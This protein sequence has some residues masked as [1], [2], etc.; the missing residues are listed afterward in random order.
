LPSGSLL[1]LEGDAR[2]GARVES[3]LGPLGYGV[4]IVADADEA[5][6]Q[7]PG[8]QLL[9]IDVVAGPRTAD[10]VCREIRS[11]PALAAIPVLCV[12][13]S[14]DVEER[15]HFLEAG[16]DDVI[17]KP[18]D[19]R[20]LEARVEALMVRFRQ[21]PDLSPVSLPGAFGRAGHRVIV[22]FSPKGGVGTTTIAVNT[23][24]A[25]AAGRQG[26]V[27]LVDLDLQW[28]QVA[29]HLNLR[30]TMTLAELS[31]DE[32]ALT[33]P[34]LL[35]SYGVAHDSGVTVLCAPSRP[36]QATLIG[37]SHVERV[38]RGATALYD[39]V[40]VDAGSS[41]DE[42][43]LTAFAQADTT[44]FTIYPEIAALKALTGLLELFAEQGRVGRTVFVLNH[45]FSRDMLKIRD[46]ETA[47]AARI[48]L[49]LPY[50]PLL[51]LKAVNEGVPIVRGAPRSEPAVR[52]GRLSGLLLGESGPVEPEAEVA[53]P[54]GRLGGLLR[55][56]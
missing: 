54:A 4:T 41:L 49:E 12:A 26:R 8:H 39:I 55:R 56:G 23:A 29:T 27:G 22:A 20:E 1:L 10:E 3:I 18:F 14:E 24:V 35:R 52:L 21:G 17:V 32:Q 13:Q 31:Q 25:L 11:T 46:I 48:E 42:R 38:I 7:A 50:D 9:I 16:A 37:P 34:E 33:E 45:V 53:R 51:Y 5:F 6:R 40:V 44:V 30:P 36:D 28:G 2:G 43:A 47:L 19:A 15:V